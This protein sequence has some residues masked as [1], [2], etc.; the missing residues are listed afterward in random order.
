MN[1]LIQARALFGRCE[2][3]APHGTWGTGWNRAGRA[4]LEAHHLALGKK[5]VL[6]E[7]HADEL[8]SEIEHQRRVELPPVGRPA[9]IF[10]I[11]GEVESKHVYG[12]HACPAGAQ[13]GEGLLMGIVSM[14]R[15][16]NEGADTTLLPRAEQIVHPAVQGLPADG[17]IAGVGAL[18]RRVDAIGDGRSPKDPESRRKVVG[19]PLDDEGIA[20]QRQVRP[21]LLAGAHGHQE[22]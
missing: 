1:H 13:R 7:I 2:G 11:A 19:E 10:E 16:N 15:K 4:A 12:E 17:R 3:G 5:E 6:R 8:G 22:P 14:R 20:A 18:G 9:R 21:V